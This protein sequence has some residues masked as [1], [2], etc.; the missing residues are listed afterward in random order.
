MSEDER[1]RDGIKKIDAFLLR[2]YRILITFLIL[3]IFLMSI[4]LPLSIFIAENGNLQNEVNPT[5][6]NGILTATAI[7][8]GFVTLQF[9]EMK[10]SNAEKILLSLPLLF[11]LMITLEWYFLET[12]TGKITLK[13][14][15]EATANCLFN[16]LY[17]IPLFVVAETH[18]AMESK[19]T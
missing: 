4:L 19:K 3:G 13:L 10:S 7:V 5:I 18:E 16:I 9:R 8:F 14:V 11:F 17:V 12:I 1:H 2:N 15:L 6:I